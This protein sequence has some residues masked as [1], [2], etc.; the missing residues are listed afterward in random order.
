MDR[1]CNTTMYPGATEQ[2][3]HITLM[4]MLMLMLICFTIGKIK[5]CAF[6]PPNC[7]VGRVHGFSHP[8]SR[9]RSKDIG[10]S[11]YHHL[12]LPTRTHQFDG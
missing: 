8:A 2:D 7:M 12:N 5:N 3:L 4:L 9:A 10:E 6:T 1:V 11:E